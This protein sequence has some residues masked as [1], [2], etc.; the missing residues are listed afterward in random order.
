M[1]RGLRGRSGA[2]PGDG[3]GA[4]RVDAGRRRGQ[5]VVPE[6]GGRG[7]DAGRAR[8]G[9]RVPSMGGSSAEPLHAR[10]R[11]PPETVGG[12]VQDGPMTRTTRLD[13]E[14]CYRAVSSRDRRFD[15]VFYTAVRTTG[16]YCR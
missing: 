3:R 4:G 2:A 5:P 16:I 15:G 7:A 14:A 1:T 11:I 12:G 13:P 10:V 8:P 9:A 6:G